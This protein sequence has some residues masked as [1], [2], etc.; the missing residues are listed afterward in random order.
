MEEGLVLMSLSKH[1]RWR[2]HRVIA[3]QKRE[4]THPV[5]LDTAEMCEKVESDNTQSDYKTASK[6]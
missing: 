4:Q 5:S 1:K 6:K 3:K 2:V